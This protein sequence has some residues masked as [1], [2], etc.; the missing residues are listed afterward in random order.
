MS[1][2][3]VSALAFGTHASCSQQGGL[4]ERLGPGSGNRTR[5][6]CHE[7]CAL[8]KSESSD[9]IDTTAGSTNNERHCDLLTVREAA[10]VLRVSESTVRNAINAGDL[11]A[12][13]FGT[14]G[15]TIRIATSHLHDYIASRSTAT[16]SKRK[17]T[18]TRADGTP[19]K[20]LNAVKLL[21]AWRRQGVLGDPP[22]GHNAPSSESSCGP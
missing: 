10:E 5:R 14:R 13:R 18:S 19:F 8:K 16:R 20:N 21:A 15:G 9:T 22:D 6:H 1:P 4:F 3:N 11:Q 17:T 2:Q 7:G 12:F